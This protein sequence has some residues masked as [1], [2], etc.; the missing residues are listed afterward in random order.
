[1]SRGETRR[2][3]DG[4]GVAVINLEKAIEERAPVEQIMEWD[5]I[6]AERTRE[7]INLVETLRSRRIR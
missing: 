3:L 6:L 2:I 7:V 5:R 1:M 4:F